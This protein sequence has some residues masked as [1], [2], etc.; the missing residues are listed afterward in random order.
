MSKKKYVTQ[1]LETL[2]DCLSVDDCI[3]VFQR[4]KYGNE[5]V[6]ILTLEYNNE[7]RAEL[8]WLLRCRGFVWVANEDTDEPPGLYTH[9]EFD[10]FLNGLIQ[11]NWHIS[12]FHGTYSHFLPI[13]FDFTGKALNDTMSGMHAFGAGSSLSSQSNTRRLTI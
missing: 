1:C 9:S 10:D 3:C 8:Y 4:F 6:A 13:E 7:K 11:Y 12:Q 2:P 5:A